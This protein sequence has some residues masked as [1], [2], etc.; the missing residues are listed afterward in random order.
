ML[1]RIIDI[2]NSLVKI[3]LDIDINKQANLINIHVVFEDKDKKIIGE[4]AKLDQEYGFIKIV[5]IIDK[6]VFIP[7][8]TKKPAFNSTI[9]IVTMDELSLI[10]GPQQITDNSKIYMG[11]SSVYAHYR[12]NVGLNDFFSSHFA[13]LGNSGAGK[14]CTVA[15]V[16]QNMMSSSSN[17]PVGANIFMFDAYGEYTR[18]FSNIS[19]I[20]PSLNYK[21]YTTNTKYPEGEVL[22]IPLW[23]LGVDDIAL[24]LGVDNP[25]QMPII[26][27]TLKLV[28]LLKDNNPEVVENKNDI[29][30]RALLDILMSGKDSSKIRDQVIAILTNFNTPS[31]NLNSI[32]SQPGYNRTLKQCIYVDQ[33]GKIQDIDVVI[34]FVNTFIKEGV[35]LKLPDGSIMYDLKDLEN[36]LD[37]ALISEG[38]LKS[39]KVFDYA[40]V[41]SVRLHSLVNSPEAEYFSYKEMITRGDYINKLSHT[42]DGKK[43]QIVNFNI[44]YVDDRMAKTLTKIISKMLF[45][46]SVSKNER[47]TVP[48]HIIIEEAHRYVQND[49]D[50]EILGYNIF[51]RITKE[52]R[53]YGVIL[54]L[55][56]QRP[57]ELSDTAISQ[58]SNFLIL[59]TLHPKDINYIKEMVPNISMETVELIKT[60]QPG[61][62]MAFGS[63]FKVPIQ[64]VIDMPSPAPLSDNSDIV[65]SWYGQNK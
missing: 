52:G 21:Y 63:A 55:I 32:I 43:C 40:N 30:A 42:Y 36:A 14:S 49:T 12:I 24:L 44:N 5:G 61:H 20:S 53:K 60:L 59:R 2:D 64:L 39:D 19:S 37:F 23:L 35:E 1:G 47:G 34:D 56:T 8:F 45:D 16:I 22:S 51:D 11:T 33:T 28:G 54:G 9:R 41:L 25:N 31:L 15:R 6:G 48:Y 26:E 58:C 18:A 65:A 10:L 57:S 3:K 27:K 50:S 13:V 46:A 17:P 4:I 62:C 29:I 7:G 38:I